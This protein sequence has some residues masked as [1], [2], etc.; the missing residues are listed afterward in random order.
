[1][2]YQPLLWAEFHHLLRVLKPIM[3]NPANKNDQK[4]ALLLEVLISMLIFSFALLGLVAL[5]AR[6]IQFSVDAEDRNRA[7]LLANEMVSTMWAQKT[8]NASTL[9]S[10][11][12]AW[13]SRVADATA[14]GLPS[15]TGTVGAANGDGVV[16]ITVTW[17]PVGP[18]SPDHTYVTQ[19]VMP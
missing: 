12:T 16:A 18:S 2:L 15:G 3:L 5:M 19:V 6:A 1:M 11:I 9:S 8:V 7:A 17:T 13:Q 4:G 14:S 10:E